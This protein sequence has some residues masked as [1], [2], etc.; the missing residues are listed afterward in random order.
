LSYEY[1]SQSVNVPYTNP[2]QKKNTDDIDATV[3]VRPSPT[4]PFAPVQVISYVP[5]MAATNVICAVTTGICA[6]AFWSA[7]KSENF[8]RALE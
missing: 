6:Y 7:F 2:A 8:S 4:Y 5:G 3:L 1:C